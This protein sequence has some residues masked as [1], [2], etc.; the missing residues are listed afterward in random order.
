M[1]DDKDDFLSP[2]AEARR[3]RRRIAHLTQ[4]MNRAKWRMAYQRKKIR[5]IEARI[6]SLELIFGTRNV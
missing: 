5:R 3:T 2:A 4:K 6:K 1:L